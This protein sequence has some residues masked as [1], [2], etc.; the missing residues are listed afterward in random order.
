M[1]EAERCYWTHACAEKA[2]LERELPRTPIKA[3]AEE[4]VACH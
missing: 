2:T 1:V 4:V 3:Q